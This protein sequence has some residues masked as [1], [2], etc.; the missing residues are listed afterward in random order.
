MEIIFVLLPLALTLAFIFLAAYIWAVRSG[1]FDDTTT[2]AYRILLDD[3]IATGKKVITP[4]LKDDPQAP[5]S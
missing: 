3:E 1:Q 5:A 4:Y 2:P